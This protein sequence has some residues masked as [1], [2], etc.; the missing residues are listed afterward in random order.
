MIFVFDLEGPLSPMDHAAEA[1]RI[2]GKKLGKP[3]FFELFQMLSLYDDEL[4]IGKWPGY[5]P[6]DTLRLI[7]PIIS[8]NLTDSEIT[9]I[10]ESATLTPGAKEL[11][12]TI[13]KDD[14]FVASTSYRQHAMTIARKLGIKEENVNCTDLPQFEGFPYLD[15]LVSIFENYKASKN[16]IK[17]VKKELDVLFWKKMP[18]EYLKTKVCGGQRKMDVVK[19]AAKERGVKLSDVMVVGDSITDITMLDGVKKA[20]GL[21]VSF[22]GNQFSAQKANLAVSSLSLM[23]LR[24][25]ID[26]GDTWAFIEAWQGAQNK[27]KLLSL[28]VATH[29]KR[30]RIPLPSYDVVKPAELKAIL[31]RQ[32]E[33]R[34]AIR[35]EYGRLT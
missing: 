21:A 11:L 8:T 20:D 3:D 31:E 29:F 15:A 30:S 10:S 17:A 28:E 23:A 9:R 24:P 12:A 6:G 14:V 32:K 13:D 19:K 4:T 26:A 2:I 35:K 16:S 22:N 18:Q 1:M 25:I 27:F 33:A 7:A 34:L 5:T